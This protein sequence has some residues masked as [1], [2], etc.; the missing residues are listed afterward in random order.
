[1]DFLGK[2]GVASGIHYI[3][4]HVFSFYRKEGIH[5]P[6]TEQIYGEI[7][8]LPL[9]PDITDSQVNQVIDTVTAGMSGR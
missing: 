9:F 1:M 5:L 7:L 6:V 3:P 8:T 2:Q 4:S